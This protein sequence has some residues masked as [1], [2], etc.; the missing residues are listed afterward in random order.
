MKRILFLH[1]LYQALDVEQVNWVRPEKMFFE[2]N[3]RDGRTFKGGSI[4]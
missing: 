1:G 4:N 3:T 2:K